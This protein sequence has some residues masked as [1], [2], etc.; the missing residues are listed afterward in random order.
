ML[1][2][3]PS[4][5]VA[6]DTTKPTIKNPIG[7]DGGQNLLAS[8]MYTRRKPSLNHEFHLSEKTL[9]QYGDKY[10]PNKKY[11]VDLSQAT[12]A[13]KE[14]HLESPKKWY[15]KIE[16]VYR[17]YIEELAITEKKD[18]EQEFCLVITI[19]D[20]NGKKDVYTETTQLLD[21]NNLITA[22]PTSITLSSHN[23]LAKLGETCL[24]HKKV[25]TIIVRTLN[26]PT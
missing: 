23:S 17:K 14:N 4:V 24:T 11:A 25:P 5:K 9:I 26:P 2:W 10:Y 12:V 13:N 8:S 21:V 6:R 15:L 19:R 1:F 18:L 22:S 7:R 3:L 20:P 16:G